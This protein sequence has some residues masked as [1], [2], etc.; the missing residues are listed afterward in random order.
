V[1]ERLAAPRRRVDRDAQV[2]DDLLL[3][4]VIVERAR[5]QRRAVDFVFER[6]VDADDARVVGFFFRNVRAASPTIFL[7]TDSRSR[8]RHR[9]VRWR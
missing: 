7:R 3:A 9:R 6:R 1:L 4:D 2:V 8:R 5:P